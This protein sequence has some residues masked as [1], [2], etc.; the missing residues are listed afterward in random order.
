MIDRFRG[1]YNFLG[2]MYLHPV[3][4]WD[5]VFPAVENAFQCAKHPEAGTLV[6]LRRKFSLCRP[7]QSKRLGR[8]L[9]L[10]PD[11]DSYRLVVMRLLLERKFSDPGLGQLLLSTR[12]H[13]L[14]EG[15]SWNDRFWG[16][17]R[18][19]GENRLGKML[20]DIRLVYAK[21][22]DGDKGSI[23]HDIEPLSP[24]ENSEWPPRMTPW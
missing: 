6:D 20:M 19:R 3:K 2:N 21:K 7:A 14:V 5:T 22:H 13:E 4:A 17:Y 23:K 15:N 16:V 24:P 11:W 1:K 10:R 12:P 8:Q 18:G 9:D